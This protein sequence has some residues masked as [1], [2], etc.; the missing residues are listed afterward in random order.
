MEKKV[1]SNRKLAIIDLILFLI[2]LGVN[3]LGASGAINNMSQKDV[4]LKY[5]TLITPANFAFSIWG[6]IYSLIFITLVYFIIKS[7]D[8]KISRGIE[9]ISPLF[10]ITCIF[11]IFWIISFSYELIALSSIF[12]LAIL[13]SL[14]LLI[15]KI[16]KFRDEIS[17]N[18]LGL[19][20]TLYASW[21]FIASIINISVFLTKINWSGFGISYSVWTIIILIIAI[22][23]VSLYS[24]I[25]KNAIFPSGVAWGFFAIYSSYNNGK[26]TPPLS[27]QIMS[28]LILGIGVYLLVMLIVFI[29]N[30]YGI[31]NKR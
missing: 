21:V 20:F 23:L 10:I 24:Y 25:Y 17:K 1:K 16:N 4:S 9:I 26:F 14:M 7:N 22:L 2:S 29:K 13:I 28:I 8:I 18:L 11:N 15:E 19:T 6:L 3:Y 27:N 12:I 30:N 31:F 5:T